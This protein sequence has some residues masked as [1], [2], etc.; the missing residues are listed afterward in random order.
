M[1]MRTMLQFQIEGFCGGAEN[2]AGSGVSISGT[3]G[4]TEAA[5][6]MT[7]GALRAGSTGSAAFGPP[8][9]QMGSASITISTPVKTACCAAAVRMR[10]TASTK[11]A[12]TAISSDRSAN[13]KTRCSIS[14]V[15]SAIGADEFFQAVH[16]ALAQNLGLHHSADQFLNRAFAKAVDDLPN[17]TGSQAAGRFR[18]T[19][20]VGPAFFLMPQVALLL[21]TPQDGADAGLLEDPFLGDHLVNGFHGARARVPDHLHDFVFQCGER[22]SN[23]GVR[24]G[25]YCHGTQRTT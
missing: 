18:G 10:R 19:I 23:A 15:S 16:F 1:P 20:N 7:T 22:G 3:I 5:A 8:E 11:A 6:A 24:T 9:I 12:A 21:Q 4:V 14:L 13:S 2:S 25:S 17:G